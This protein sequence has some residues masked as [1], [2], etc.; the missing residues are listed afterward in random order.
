MNSDVCV[1]EGDI[2]LIHIKCV[3]I[4]LKRI[5]YRFEG[6]LAL[7]IDSRKIYRQCKLGLR[8]YS[9]FLKRKRDAVMLQYCEDAA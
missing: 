3:P 4:K 5:S 8:E 9:L 6:A 2:H 1:V 7:N